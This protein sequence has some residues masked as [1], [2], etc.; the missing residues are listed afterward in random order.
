MGQYTK[1]T[2]SEAKLHLANYLLDT[3]GFDAEPLI[4]KINSAKDISDV[5][6]VINFVA[7][8]TNPKYAKAILTLWDDLLLAVK[9]GKE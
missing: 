5:Q 9:R 8:K 2:L 7:Q 4:D 1:L 6:L 3:L